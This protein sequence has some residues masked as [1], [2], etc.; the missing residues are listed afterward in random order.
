MAAA[1][2]LGRMNAQDHW[3]DLL[4]LLSPAETSQ[5][6]RLHASKALA[7]LAGGVDHGYDVAAWRK[8]FDRGQ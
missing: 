2:A 1:V 3:Q 8:T 5:N 7:E 4:A 6:V